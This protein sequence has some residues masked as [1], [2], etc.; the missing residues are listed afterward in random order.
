[1]YQTLFVCMLRHNM[2]LVHGVPDSLCMYAASQYATC[3][4]CTR[5]SLYVAASQY[6]T[7][8]GCTRLSSYVSCV[9]ICYLYRVYHTLFVCM[10]RHNML[11]VQGVPDSLHICINQT[12]N[13][14]N[15]RTLID[16][17]VMQKLFCVEA[18]CLTMVKI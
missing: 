10:L 8:T 6:A 3:K 11:H 5:L 14:Y 17:L 7:S 1:M 4:G 18:I 15:S 16:I 13:Y 9:T 12:L 2:L